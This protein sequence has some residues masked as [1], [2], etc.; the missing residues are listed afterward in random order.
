[1]RSRRT[2]GFIVLII[3]VG[4]AVGTVLGEVMALV[5]PKGVVQEFFTKSWMP[6]LGPGT[7][8]LVLFSLTLGMTLKV[9]GAGIIGILVAVYLLRWVF[10]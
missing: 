6:T 4:A 5:L 1:M 2:F 7:L 10:D 9:N 8:D 3:F